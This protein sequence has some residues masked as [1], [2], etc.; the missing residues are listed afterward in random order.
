MV[1]EGTGTRTGKWRI[2]LAEGD[3]NIVREYARLTRLLFNITP[4]IRDRGT[5]YEAYYCSRLAYEYLS[6]IGDHHRGKKTGKLF[7]PRVVRRN[8]RVL[9]G[10]LC[11]IFSVEASAKFSSNI[12]LTLE[13]LEPRL[14]HELSRTL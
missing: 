12:R 13:M 14:I 2:E 11:G 8:K 3:I 1:S 4:T 9:L 5:W 10:F 7:I 6:R